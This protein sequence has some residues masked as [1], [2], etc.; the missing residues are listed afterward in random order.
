MNFVRLAVVIISPLGAYA[1]AFNVN[2]GSAESFG[3][4][5]GS[6]ITNTGPTIVNGDVGLSPGS[7]IIGFPPGVVNGSIFFGGN[8][9]AALAKSDLTSA[10]QFAS[11]E[12]CPADDNLSGT[13]L[14]GITLTPGVYCFSSDAQLTGTGPNAILTLDD[15]GDPNAVFVF[16]I[17]DTLTT[18]SGTSVSIIG[19]PGNIYWQVGTSATLGV[20]SVF[21]GNILAQDDIT[22]NT[23]A[24]IGC[25]SAL[26]QTG[27]VTLD[28]STIQ[29]GCSAPGSFGGPAPSPEPSTSLMLL[30]IGAS[31]LLWLRKPRSVRE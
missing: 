5:A 6:T 8:S 22:L 31:A 21:E 14:G 3:V 12:S 18:G 26:T 24:T 4:L 2:L 16:Q 27:A 15:E 7:Q 30:L 23:G 11:G 17:G 29:I 9:V 28:D 13:N 10:Y 19:G 20:N 25:G 1:S